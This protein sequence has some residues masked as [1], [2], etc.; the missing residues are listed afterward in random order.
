MNGWFKT[1]RSETP[2]RIGN[3]KKQDIML[4]LDIEKGGMLSLG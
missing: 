3:M 2:K 4:V 1:S